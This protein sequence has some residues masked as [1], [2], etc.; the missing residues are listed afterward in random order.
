MNTLPA[1]NELPD[2]LQTV[3]TRPLFVMQLDVKPLVMVGATPGPFRPVG[4][5][6]S[7]RFEGDRLSGQVIDG[8]SDWLN[9]VIAVG[10]G[11]RF[12]D[13]PVYSAFEVL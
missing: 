5:V 10:T 9:R 4:I 8:S 7:G 3:R 6:P 2:G 11:H 1:F 13:G 12:R